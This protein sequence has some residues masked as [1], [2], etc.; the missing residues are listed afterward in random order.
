MCFLYPGAYHNKIK[1][2]GKQIFLT[3]EAVI[4]YFEVE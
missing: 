2:K 3:K 4:D 1:G